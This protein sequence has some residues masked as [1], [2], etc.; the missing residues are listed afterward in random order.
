MIQQLSD[1]GSDLMVETISRYGELVEPGKWK[2]G[3]ALL[4]FVLPLFCLF[5]CCCCFSFSD[6]TNGELPCTV[7]D[8]PCMTVTALC[9]QEIRQFRDFLLYSAI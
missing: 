2:G 6:N 7:S 5:V 8:T 3:E 9:A 4:L 1:S